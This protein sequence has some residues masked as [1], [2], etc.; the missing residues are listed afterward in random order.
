VLKRDLKDKAAMEA[1]VRQVA[2]EYLRDP[3]INS[4]GIGYATKAGRRT[5]RLALQFTVG[6]KLAPEQLEEARTR[7]IPRSITANGITFDTDVV[8]RDFERQPTAVEEITKAERKRRLDPMMPG[9]SIGHVDST[10]G[11]LGCLVREIATGET[12]MLSNWHVLH[13][14]TNSH[15][16]QLGD[17]IVQ[18]GPY[19]DNRVAQ[20]VCGRL[21][22]SFLGLAGDCA[23]ASITGRDAVET[24]ADL[25][26][27]VRSVGDAE[28]GDRVVKSGRTTAVTYGLVTRVHTITRLSYGTLGEQLIGGFEIGP[29]EDNPAASNE[30]SMGG[31]SGSA[32]M[33]VT[34]SGAARD[35]I[36]GLH[37]AGETVEPA[38]YAVAAYASSVFEKLEIAPLEPPAEGDVNVITQAAAGYDRRFLPSQ[39]LPPPEPA[40]D[41]VRDDLQ[42][43]LSG[44]LVRHHTH[45]S[46]AMSAARRFCRWVAWNVDGSG[47]WQLS[48]DGIDFVLDDAYEPDEQVGDELYSDNPLDRGH[49]ARRADLLWGTREEAERANV[50]SF[51]FTNITPQLNDFNQSRMHGLWGELEDAVYEDVDVDDLRISVFGGPVFKDTDFLFRG[52]LV[53]RSFWKLIAYVESGTLKAKAFVLTQD[54]LEARL[55]SL[56]LEEFKLYQV[57]VGELTD[58]IRLDFGSLED[59]DTMAAVPE[60]VGAPVQRITA[61]S[62]IMRIG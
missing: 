4:V 18:P 34:G 62:E 22:R 54:D 13:G 42:P 31:D 46:L 36:V 8:E 32:W 33:A 14:I 17:Q 25:D 20:N 40:D 12:R 49:V 3:N 39:V 28:L 56:G 10:A 53:P 44:D 11:T 26:V 30:I 7:P 1:A 45:F 9:I 52:V 21:V 41:D 6:R 61:R 15:P 55:E 58:L 27:P 16:P 19:D 2:R 43:T 59:A 47:L 35:M 24:I 48:R 50:E 38:E 29:D 60:T 23:I 37:F 57:S 51:R 5:R